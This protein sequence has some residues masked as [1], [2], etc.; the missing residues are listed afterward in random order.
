MPDQSLPACP[1]FGQCG[2]CQ[3]QDIPYERELLLKSEEVKARLQA[4]LPMPDEIFSKIV[5]SPSVYHYR[6]RLD[7]KLKKTRDGR[8]YIGFSPVGRGPVVEIES[9]PIAMAAIS[10]FIPRLKE[11][12]VARLPQDYRIANLT[13]RCGDGPDVRWGGIGRGSTKL[14][15]AEYL[16]TVIAGTRISY[17]LDTFF[18]ANLS[19]LPLLREAIRA[20]PVFSKEA[21]F[22]DLYGGVGLFSLFVHDLVARAVNIEENVHAAWVARH[23]ISINRLTGLDVLVGRVEVVL[24]DL[25]KAVSSDRNVVM[26]DPPRAGLGEEAVGLLNRVEKVR[27]LIYLSCSPENLLRDLQG[28][29]RGPWRT[30]SVK[31]MDF[32]PRTRHV[33]TLVY[34]TRE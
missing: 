4:G 21:V 9:C 31:P 20:F 34:L 5:P 8:V 32:F 26:V 27:H 13:V 11:E 25:L 14:L 1:V 29:T 2:G 28:L 19:I 3:Y 18:Q 24:V 6:N 16:S 17:S 10:D 15:P 7:L 22:F 23:N 33:E 12:A 30:V